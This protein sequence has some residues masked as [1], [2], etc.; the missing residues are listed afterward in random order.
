VGGVTVE[1]PPAPTS[2]LGN[3]YANVIPTVAGELIVFANER[4]LLSVALH[5][6]LLAEAWGPLAPHFVTQVYNLLRLIGVP[7]HV[8][9]RETAEMQEVEF[10]KTA[11]RSILGSL[12]EISLHYQLA[13]ER[14]GGRRPLNLAEEEFHLSR[15]VHTP[16]D[17]KYPSDIAK[18]LLAE[19]YGDWR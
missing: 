11:S 12:N 19:R 6:E 3:W 7:E 18:N 5:I 14:D 15:Y 17:Y 8:A 10:A 9:E 2:V 4:T 1:D 16:L 13:A